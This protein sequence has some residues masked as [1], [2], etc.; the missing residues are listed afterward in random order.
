MG[1]RIIQQ[2][3]GK[4]GPRYRVRRRAYR[5]EINYPKGQGKAKVVRLQ[6]SAGHTAPLAKLS[7]GN[8]T[9]F[10][11]AF[12]GMFEGQEI[13]V[14]GQE[15]KNGN[16]LALKDIPITTQVYNIETRPGSGGKLIRTAGSSA[17]ITKK[18]NGKVGIL[19][20]SKKEIELNENCRASI[21][22]IAGDG[23]LEKPI[24]KAGRNFYRMKAR[25]KL[26]PRT[27][28]LKMNVIDH[29]FGSGRGKKLA[30]GGKG[31][32]PK[33]NAPPGANVGSMHAS[34]TGRKKK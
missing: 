9:F 15:I 4:G 29:P 12:R 14:G 17:M 24:M 30:H 28:A 8:D 6:N 26:W 10:N 19:M 11:P 31:K 32:I 18:V 23:R 22:I 1:K 7:L 13:S 33:R 16:I 25:N 20:P 5:F 34:R 3:R 21:G 27:S 2:A